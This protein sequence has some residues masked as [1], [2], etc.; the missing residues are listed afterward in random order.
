MALS[1]AQMN[2]L[3]QQRESENFDDYVDDVNEYGN[4]EEEEDFDEGNQEDAGRNAE[5]IADIKDEAVSSWTA[6]LKRKF[7]QNHDNPLLFASEDEIAKRDELLQLLSSTNNNSNQQLQQLRSHIDQMLRYLFEHKRKHKI[8]FLDP[9]QKRDN[10][11]KLLEE[12][13]N[14][15]ERVYQDLQV[16]FRDS[17]Q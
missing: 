3:Q 15:Y 16:M 7:Q 5:E 14:L 12:T 8:S 4:E 11:V 13:I 6:E 17:Q 2:K 10:N 9:A 1:S